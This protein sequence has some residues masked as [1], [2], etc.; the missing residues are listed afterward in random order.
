MVFLKDFVMSFSRN[1]R[2][3]ETAET[4]RA[5]ITGIRMGEDAS[6]I[7][8]KLDILGKIPDGTLLIDLEDGIRTELRIT[9]VRLFLSGFPKDDSSGP[10]MIFSLVPWIVS[11]LKRENPLFAPLINYA[12]FEKSDLELAG[13]LDD[14]LYLML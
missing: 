5:A 9:H 6:G 7:E 11:A 2:L 12:D 10:A 14:S 1:D 8:L 3:I 4:L 13:H